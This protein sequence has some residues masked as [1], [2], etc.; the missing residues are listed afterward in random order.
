MKSLHKTE[1][2]EKVLKES[3]EKPVILFKHSNACPVSAD[4]HKK[5][6]KL[7]RQGAIAE[8]MYIVIV[9]NARD[10]SDKVAEELEVEHETPQVII[11]SNG[12]AVYD[13]SHDEIDSD[14]VARE[15]VQAR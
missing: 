2:W 14:E 9:Q 12:E 3:Q 6:K 4:A 1:V 10:I 5:I 7:E 13:V 15:L 8:S 11:I